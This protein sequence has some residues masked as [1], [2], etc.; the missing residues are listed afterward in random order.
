MGITRKGHRGTG[1]V[2]IGAWP[3]SRAQVPQKD[4]RYI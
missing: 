3:F 1:G 4:R 2:G